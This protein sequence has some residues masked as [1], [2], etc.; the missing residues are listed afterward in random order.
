MSFIKSRVTLEDIL[1]SIGIKAIRV[2][3]DL[4]N[5]SPNFSKNLENS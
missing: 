3:T 1:Q 5:H 4:K 2:K